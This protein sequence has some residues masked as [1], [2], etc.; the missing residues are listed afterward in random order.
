MNSQ[1]SS[2]VQFASALCRYIQVGYLKV[3]IRLEI[4]HIYV[5]RIL[6]RDHLLVF[7]H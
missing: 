3:L 1:G 7:G 4:L 6:G 5:Y 2:N